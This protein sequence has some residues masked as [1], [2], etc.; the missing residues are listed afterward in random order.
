MLAVVETAGEGSRVLGRGPTPTSALRNRLQCLEIFLGASAEKI[1]LFW[2]YVGD[3]LL[4]KCNNQKYFWDC[5]QKKM[6]GIFANTFFGVRQDY[7]V[8]L[9]FGSTKISD[10]KCHS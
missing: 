3:H 2:K 9:D 8:V 7:T 1:Y 6:P 10:F 5:L 4:K